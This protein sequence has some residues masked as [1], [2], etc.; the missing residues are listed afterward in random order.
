MRKVMLLAA[1][2]AM[3]LAAAAPAFAQQ[4]QGTIQSAVGNNNAQYNVSAICSNIV[5]SFGDVAQQQSGNAD[6]VAANNSAAIA[7]V[8]QEQGV[9][10][11]AVV[12]CVEE[13]AIESIPAAAAPVVAQYEATASATA[14]A[15]A[16]V[17][18]EVL[19]E[20]GGASLLALGAG[21]LLVAGGLLARR[22][23]R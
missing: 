16:A 15:T 3:A 10:Q 22:I 14:S 7:E 6:A 20:T 18:E 17:E 9:T 1:M 12:E 11:A 8:A 19:P 21:A 23:V 2:L 4:A 5:G 13:G